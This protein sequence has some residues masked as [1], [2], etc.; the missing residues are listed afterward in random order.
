MKRKL[1]LIFGGKSGEYE[2]SLK[3]SYNVIKAIDKSKYDV[4]FI[5][6]TREGA[7]KSYRGDIEKIPTDAWL[8]E[9]EELPFEA[10]DN[11][12]VFFPVLHGTFGEDGTIQ[13]LFEML[14]KAY[15]GCGVLGSSVCMDKVISKYICEACGIP[16]TEYLSFGSDE[17]AQNACGII[18]SAIEKLSF[19]M[20]VKP[21]NMG[22]SVGIS[23][24]SDENMLK[25]AIAEALKYDDKI[26]VEKGIDGDEVE[27]A[28]LGNAEP[29]ASLPGMIKPCNE[30]YDYEA[31][32]LSGSD[33]KILIPAPL[34]SETIDRLKFLSLKAFKAHGCSGLAR[35]D[36]FVRKSDNKVI[37]NELNTL[38]GF[39]N[40]SMYPMLWMQSGIS[41][42]QLIDKLIELGFERYENKTKLSFKKI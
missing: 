9:A 22:S 11:I 42:S 37:L 8:A 24:A 38:P 2:V 29:E 30:F 20:F 33:S 1:G 39:T 41:Y 16:V 7:W 40:I 36:F 4:S 21:A 19:P 15:V 23:K 12:D 3:S 17:Y 18:Q 28:V 10:L 5:G 6:I 34:D 25:I 27:V 14:G 26:I 13:G 35:I 31:K 32:Y